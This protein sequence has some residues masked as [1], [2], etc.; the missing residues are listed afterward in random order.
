MEFLELF[1]EILANIPP[2]YAGVAQTVSAAMSWVVLAVSLAVCFF[3]YK[4]HHLWAALAF[5]G[6]G[7]LLGAVVGAAFPGVHVYLIL[8]LGLALGVLGMLLSRKLLKLEI[9][10]A[11]A[12]L[13]YA[14]LPNVLRLALPET[15]AILIGLAAAIVVGLVAVKFKYIVTIVTTTCTGAVTAAPLLLSLGG[16]SGT[17]LRWLVIAVLAA[18]GLAVQFSMEKRVMEREKAERQARKEERQAAKVR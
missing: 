13:V 4:I 11:N 15:A 6:L 1:E 17:L 7:F 18:A 3:G 16:W 10:F 12:F 8:A 5:F 2:E 9:F 14:A